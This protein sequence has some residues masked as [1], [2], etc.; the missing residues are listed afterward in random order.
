MLAIR[1]NIT[2]EDQV[3]RE[4]Y[5]G[6]VKDCKSSD[7]PETKRLQKSQKGDRPFAEEVTERV[8]QAA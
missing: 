5:A 3:H 7:S 6:G 1:P 4:R 8:N 2:S